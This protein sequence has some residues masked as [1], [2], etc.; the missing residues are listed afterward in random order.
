M[1]AQLHTI[2]LETANV[3]HSKILEIGFQ[4]SVNP[5]CGASVA[6]P[7]RIKFDHEFVAVPSI[8]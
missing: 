2:N 3:A 4:L 8:P 1:K 7:R 5:E 6:L